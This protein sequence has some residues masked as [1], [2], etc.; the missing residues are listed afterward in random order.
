MRKWGGT[1]RWVDGGGNERL[2]VRADQAHCD[3][4]AGEGVRDPGD[5][6]DRAADAGPEAE[7]GL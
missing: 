7:R 6:G 3:A 5:V 4:G 2:L 1:T